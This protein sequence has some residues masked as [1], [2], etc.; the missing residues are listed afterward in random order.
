[1][2]V[3]VGQQELVHGPAILTA[4]VRSPPPAILVDL[5]IST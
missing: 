1:V 4:F 2:H 5:Q 3:E